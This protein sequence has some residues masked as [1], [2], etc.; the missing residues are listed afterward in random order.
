MS[1]APAFLGISPMSLCMRKYT[2]GEDGARDP[3]PGR[4]ACAPLSEPLVL[5]CRM[6]LVAR[7]PHPPALTRPPLILQSLGPV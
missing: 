3:E 6:E 5:S 7:D 1:Q 2:E 4:G